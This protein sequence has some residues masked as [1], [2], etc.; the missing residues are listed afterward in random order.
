MNE[1]E[2]YTPAEVRIN[3]DANRPLN[4]EADARLDT[5]AGLRL[6]TEAGL[7]V[8]TEAGM[9][10]DTD[11]DTPCALL[12]HVKCSPVKEA[13]VEIIS[14]EEKSSIELSKLGEKKKQIDR[15]LFKTPPKKEN[16]CKDPS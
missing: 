11:G 13:V 7:R 12:T 5:E 3:A 9:R 15:D 16:D 8:D 14:E 4:T 6:D 10:L 2:P 1:T